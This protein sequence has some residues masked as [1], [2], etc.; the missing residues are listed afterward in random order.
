MILHIL[1]VAGLGKA[2]QQK[3]YEG[4]QEAASGIP[5]VA[6]L[7]QCY[8]FW[9]SSDRQEEVVAGDLPG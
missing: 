9:F 6:Q 8:A 4:T 7:P 1:F 3:L 2:Q 5:L